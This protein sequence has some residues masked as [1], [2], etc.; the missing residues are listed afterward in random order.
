MNK[1]LLIFLFCFALLACNNINY[2][3]DE[4]LQTSKIKDNL[5]TEY[6][7][8]YAGGVI[9]GDVETVYVTDST[10]FRKYLGKKMDH[11]GIIVEEF[12][13]Y[14]ILVLKYDVHTYK[15]LNAKI[16]DIDDL[17]EEEKFE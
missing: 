13:K 10:H 4:H 14:N 11:Q 15:V 16:Y 5:Y 6:Y 1:Y 2:S 7:R 8:T 12:G 3:K 17:K 9:G